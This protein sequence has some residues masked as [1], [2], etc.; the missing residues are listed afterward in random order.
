MN[1]KYSRETV[2]KEYYDLKLQTDET[3][4][5]SVIKEFATHNYHIPFGIYF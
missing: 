2:I 3:N 5:I 1:F 4:N